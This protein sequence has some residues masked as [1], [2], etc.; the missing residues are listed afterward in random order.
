MNRRIAAIIV[1]VLFFL[2]SCAPDS[3]PI[4][5][6]PLQNG[7]DQSIQNTNAALT[8]VQVVNN[9][10]TTSNG[11]NANTN[12]AAVTTPKS[13]PATIT[14][15]GDAKSCI[16]NVLDGKKVVIAD[17]NAFLRK[18][19]SDAPVG[20]L[21]GACFHP[22]D[23]TQIQQ[24]SH[25]IF[26]LMEQNKNHPHFGNLYILTLEDK[27]I[28]PLEY[29]NKKFHDIFATMSVAADGKRAL[30]VEKGDLSTLKMLR[31]DNNEVTTIKKLTGGEMWDGSG[32]WSEVYLETVWK[33]EKE[34]SVKVYI[35]HEVDSEPEELRSEFVTLP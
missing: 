14:L 2:T 26:R 23:F 1:P 5:Q 32:F 25:V 3:T 10:N 18:K 28:V 13:T 24:S 4:V 27:K 17:V 11:T 6:A 12:T 31:F 8:P 29:F 34:A 7:A 21:Q 19:I 30:F 9:S 16:F 33:N 22:E 15:Q 35:Q 20:L